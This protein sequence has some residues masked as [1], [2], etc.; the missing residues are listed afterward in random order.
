V[1]LS[2]T[3]QAIDRVSGPARSAGASIRAL[4]NRVTNSIRRYGPAARALDRVRDAARRL[5]ASLQRAAAAARGLAQRGM[6]ALERAAYRAGYAIGSVARKAAA[7]AVNGAGAIGAGAL[8]GTLLLGKGI[9]QT[10]GEF[11][12]Y[13]VA[14]EGTLR[15]SA[16]A[17]AAMAWVAEFAAKTPYQIGEVTAAFVKAQQSG[18]NPFSGSLTT[19]GDA[20]GA[21]NKSLDDAIE[22]MKDAQTF[23]FERMPEFGITA[24]SDGAKATF[25]YLDREGKS[26]KKTVLKDAVAIREGILSILRELY[27]GGMVRQSLTLFGT[28]ANIADKVTKFKLA[29]ASKGIFDRVKKDLSGILEWADKIEKDGR[30]DGWAQQVSDILTELWDRAHRFIANTDWKSVALGIGTIA[31]ALINVVSWIGKAASAWMNWQFTMERDK[32]TKTI[33]APTL[34]QSMFT[35]RR[36]AVADARRRMVQLDTVQHGPQATQRG[37]RTIWPEGSIRAPATPLK[38]PA[39]RPDSQRRATPA[40]PGKL[41]VDI[42]LRGEAAPRADVLSVRVTGIDIAASVKRGRAMNGPA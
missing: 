30:L 14:L 23:S 27:D 38:I 22:M 26:A 28:W 4:A 15:S 33:E 16:K 8:A 39:R 17:K 18:L 19:L 10:A 34:W 2:L 5:P 24:S 31:A 20:A 21:M 25:S 40:K 11:E 1:R 7:F 41:T 42:N 29:V 6:A 13:Q 12:Q 35:D 9:I 37:K 3:L 32:L 36:A